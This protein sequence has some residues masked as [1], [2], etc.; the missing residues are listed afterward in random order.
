MRKLRVA[1][2]AG[3]W[4]GEREISLESGKAIYE[5]LSRDKYEVL[6]FDP[7]DDLE[8]LIGARRDLDVVFNVLHGP[9]GEDGCIQGLLRVLGIPVVGSGVLSSAVSL[10]KSVAKGLYRS[11]GLRVARDVVVKRGE[12]VSPRDMLMR[13]GGRVVVKP[14]AQGS[15]LGTSVCESEGDLVKGLDK[16]FEYGGEA[17]VEEYM[18]GREVTCCVLG[19]E[20]PETLPLIEIVPGEGSEFFDFGAKYVS[21]GT[22]EICPAMIPESIGNRVRFYGKKAHE[23]L[24]CKVWSRTD[25]IIGKKDDICVLETNT[26]PGMTLGSLFPLAA[27]VAGMPLSDL[28]D[29]M[30]E[31][32]LESTDPW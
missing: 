23:V 22:R 21:K 25:V 7:S 11:A 5:A 18:E 32:S 1:V 15:S 17:L 8:E 20:D 29:R 24:K 16:A 26:L 13:L 14:V 4:S 10:N 9:Y 6:W 28:V 31:L 27:R 12:D 2:L 3:G 19:N 30:V